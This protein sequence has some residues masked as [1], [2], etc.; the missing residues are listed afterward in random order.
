VEERAVVA[1]ALRLCRCQREYIPLRIALLILALLVLLLL[2]AATKPSTLRVQRAITINASPH[3]VFQ[4]L[5]LSI[6]RKNFLP[7]LVV[8]HVVYMLTTCG[9]FDE[10]SISALPINQAVG[11]RLPF[12]E[13]S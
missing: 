6:V 1:A 9:D 2:Y 10:G 12:G 7:V 8:P 13:L 3:K 11:D 5:D 4:L